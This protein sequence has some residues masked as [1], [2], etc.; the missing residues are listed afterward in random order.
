MKITD[1]DKSILAELVECPEGT[2]PLTLTIGGRKKAAMRLVRHGFADIYQSGRMMTVV[3]TS[4]G[5]SF[6]QKE[7]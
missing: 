3:A 5:R 2:G 7:S 6:I 4:E 1:S